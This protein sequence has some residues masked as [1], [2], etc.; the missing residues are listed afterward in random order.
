MTLI[1]FIKNFVRPNTLIRLWKPINGGHQM[2]YVEN[3]KCPGNIDAVCMEWELEK[4]RTWQS[5]YKDNKVLGVTDILVEDFYR[6][7]VNI[8]IEVD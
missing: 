1:D 8:V 3:E 7:A 5:K 6:E 4:G 2:L